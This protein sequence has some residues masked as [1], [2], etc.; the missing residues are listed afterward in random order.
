M[1]LEYVSLDGALQAPGHAGEDR[2]GGF[3]HGWTGPFLPSTP[4]MSARRPPPPSG[5]VLL[6]YRPESTDGPG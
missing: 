6:T 4:A 5:L 3:A 2:A 1:I